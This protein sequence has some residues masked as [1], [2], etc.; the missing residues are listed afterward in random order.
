M[1]AKKK[2]PEPDIWKFLNKMMDD[3][4]GASNNIDKRIDNVV[5]Q[6]NETTRTMNTNLDMIARR[7]KQNESRIRHIEDLAEGE[8]DRDDFDRDGDDGPEGNC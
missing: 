5:K 3:L 7:I 8:D 6:L 2:K 4:I 1:S